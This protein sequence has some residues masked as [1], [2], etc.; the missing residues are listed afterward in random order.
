RAMGETEAEALGADSMGLQDSFH[1]EGVML[2]DIEMQ[3][4]DSDW[5]EMA[6]AMATLAMHASRGFLYAGHFN[7]DEHHGGEIEYYEASAV[8]EIPLPQKTEVK[9][10]EDYY[11]LVE[12]AHFSFKATNTER[13]EVH[14]T[15]RKTEID[16]HEYY[17]F[18]DED[19]GHVQYNDFWDGTFY[20]KDQSLVSAVHAG[21]ARELHELDRDEA[22]S[23]QVV[24]NNHGQPG[25]TLYA[26]WKESD[27]FVV[28]THDDHVSVD[29]PAGAFADCARIRV[30]A[31][32][33]MDDRMDVDTH[34]QY[35]AKGVGL[36]KWEKG[37]AKLELASYNVG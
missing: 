8:G 36:V 24:Y 32:H 11:P 16:G 21:N 4:L 25:D 7:N 22:Y 15:T 18:D 27:V 17:Y 3:A 13:D 23:T 30:D 10:E 12:N 34:F 6:V 37:D 20:V 33:V 28:F 1:G 35:F 26:I 14:W 31:Y 5:D 29:V 19:T 2:I 9:R